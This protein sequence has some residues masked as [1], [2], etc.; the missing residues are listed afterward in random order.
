[1]L[2]CLAR[3]GIL[4][5]KS[6]LFI[7]VDEHAQQLSEFPL[8]GCEVLTIIKTCQF[9]CQALIFL[10]S[11]NHVRKTTSQKLSVSLL[12]EI[13]G[14]SAHFFQSPRSYSECAKIYKTK[15]R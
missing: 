12:V 8:L 5:W 15:T 11:T 9:L 13:D 3:A 10:I 14:G 1:M 2:E 4:N 6:A 7:L